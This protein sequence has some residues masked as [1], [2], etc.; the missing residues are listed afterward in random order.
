MYST[1][2]NE[3]HVFNESD[4]CE[5]ICLPSVRGHFDIPHGVDSDPVVPVA[6]HTHGVNTEDFNTSA[7][8]TIVMTVC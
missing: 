1:Q 3:W 4:T 8:Q 2:N 7:N 6:A 5:Y